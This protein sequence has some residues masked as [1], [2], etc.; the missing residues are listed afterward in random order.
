M[1][2]PFQMKPIV[3]YMTNYIYLGQVGQVE[4]KVAEWPIQA[5]KK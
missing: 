3:P 4:T 1:F 2:N 5:D